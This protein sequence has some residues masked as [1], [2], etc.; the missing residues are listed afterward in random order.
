MAELKDELASKCL[1]DLALAWTNPTENLPKA[2][3]EKHMGSQTVVP[4][5]VY[6]DGVQYSNRPDSLLA[7]TIEPILASFP[8]RI[9]AVIRKKTMCRCNCQGYCSLH[10]VW[11]AIAWSLRSLLLGVHP[12][13]DVHGGDLP[14]PLQ[15]LAGKALPFQAEVVQLRSDIGELSTSVGLPGSTSKIGGCCLCQ[16][17]NA[18]MLTA[19][20]QKVPKPPFPTLSQPDLEQ[21]TQSCE[22]MVNTSTWSDETWQALLNCLEPSIAAK[23]MALQTH[24][25]ELGLVRGDRLEPS[26]SLPD[27]GA[28]W[29]L[30]LLGQPSK[31]PCVG[32]Y[33][34]SLRP[35]QLIFWRR[36]TE[37]L[38]RRRCPLFSNCLDLPDILAVDSMH[39][40]ALGVFQQYLGHT[41]QHLLEANVASSTRRLVAERD[42]E[43]LQLLETKFRNWCQQR[44]ASVSRAVSKGEFL[45]GKFGTRSKPSCHF[46]AAQTVDIVRWLADADHGLASL[47][48][49][50]YALNAF[51]TAASALQRLW[52]KL[53]ERRWQ[54]SRAEIVDNFPYYPI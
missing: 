26:K 18:G 40:L 43:C 31:L 1:A 23:G 30:N 42:A 47:P 14:L 33:V 29:E 10:Q 11:S 35:V 15:T 25:P 16:A 27:V 51:K 38:V 2:Y 45:S 24:M 22:R 6:M 21:A 3:M 37:T 12:S 46:K 50:I 39:I 17:S 8:P 44:R 13:E 5:A 36:T 49:T 34:G 7:I 54:P 32:K 53:Q 52:D 28:L 41:V 9:I 19:L 48:G 20:E 4:M